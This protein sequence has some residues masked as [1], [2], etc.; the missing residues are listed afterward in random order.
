ME[1][2]KN[3]LAVAILSA[4]L[5]GCGGDSSSNG[6]ASDAPLA[7]FV[8]CE[9]GDAGDVCTLKGTIDE[10]YT[11]TSDKT[12]VLSGFVKV[13]LGNGGVNSA[14]DVDAL[15]AK[16]ATLTIEKGT[17]VRALND[18]VLLVTR[19]S[20][21]E[22]VGTKDEPITFSSLQDDDLDGEGEWGGVII[23]GFAPQYGVGNTGPCFTGNVD[24]VCNVVGEGGTGVGLYGGNEPAD[25][26][27]TLKYVRIAEG[28]KVAGPN[29][30]IN[31]LTLQG[32]GHGT[33]I[34]YIQVHNNLAVQLT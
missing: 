31:G 33:T 1:L 29:N 7:S 12:W 10:D 32:V 9:A 23:Q 25:N 28:G 6:S 11:L 22:A 26:S 21:L 13:G 16:G 14:A 24:E 19:G 3:L 5:V 30:E 4:T 18:G 27:G 15:K 34:D 20:K 8:S 17:D 2:N